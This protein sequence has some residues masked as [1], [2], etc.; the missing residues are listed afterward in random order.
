M[1]MEKLLEPPNSFENTLKTALSV[2]TGQL[3]FRI[4]RT[5]GIQGGSS[6]LEFE[7]SHFQHDHKK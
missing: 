4:D 5:L 7:V 3:V 1:Y 6:G 2:K